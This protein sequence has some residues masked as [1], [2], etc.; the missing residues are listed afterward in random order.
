M[1]AASTPAPRAKSPND[2]RPSSS[3]HTLF[4]PVFI[5]FIGAGLLALYQVM[6]MEDQYEQMTQSV[7][8]M[9]GKVKR[10]QYEKAKFFRIARDLLQLAPKDPIADQLV[11]HYKL[12]QME[13]AEPELVNANTPSDVGISA[14]AAS[15]TAEE[16]NAASLLPGTLTN[17][18]STNV[19]PLSVPNPAAK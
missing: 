13:Q 9:D 8:R 17:A 6:A 5:F 12:R 15:Q 19:P 7:D 11:V 16:T 14:M 3:R 18:A 10:A 1:S 4:W 2:P